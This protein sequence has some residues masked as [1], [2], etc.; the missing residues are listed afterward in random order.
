MPCSSL[1]T[2]SVELFVF[3]GLEIHNKSFSSTLV[4]P[5]ARKH[6]LPEVTAGNACGRYS[7]FP[8]FVK[9]SEFRLAVIGIS[10]RQHG[11]HFL[12]V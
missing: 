8:L 5:T 9:F 4:L 10:K 1:P 11:T 7:L 3:S 12:Y 2:I 6:C